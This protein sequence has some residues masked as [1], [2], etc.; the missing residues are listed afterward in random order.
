MARKAGAPR[1]SQVVMK[2]YHAWQCERSGVVERN[3]KHYC[4]QHDPERL[5]A[6]RRREKE[7]RETYQQQQKEIEAEGRR[8]AA[9]LG[10]PGDVHYHVPLRGREMGGY[11]RALVVPFEDLKRLIAERGK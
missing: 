2:E 10:V 11:V 5:A 8:L 4:R 6:D 1:C 7:V 9:L 3:G